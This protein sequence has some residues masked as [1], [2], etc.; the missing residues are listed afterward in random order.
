MDSA[1]IEF[2]NEELLQL[3]NRF[4]TDQ[5]LGNTQFGIVYRGKLESDYSKGL[6]PWSD[7]FAFGVLV[8][9]LISKR[10]YDPEEEG[11]RY[12]LVLDVW[13]K[14]QHEERPKRV[15]KNLR[16]SKYSKFFLV[17]KS[18]ISGKG[19]SCRDGF[20]LTRLVMECVEDS[21]CSWPSI[22]EVVNFLLK[23]K[24]VRHYGSDLGV[25]HLLCLRKEHA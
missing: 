22:N 15:R 13:A 18:L 8:L 6:G 12:E 9:A 4:S 1:L 2:Q 23:L 24:I 11:I 16:Y 21:V 19:Y 17:H 20:A 25:D 5:V 10:A 14:L 7:I 3:T